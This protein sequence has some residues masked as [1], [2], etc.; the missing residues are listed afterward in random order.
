MASNCQSS[1]LHGPTD[2]KSHYFGCLKVSERER[3]LKHLPE[4]SRAQVEEEENRIY[5]LRLILE[6]DSAKQT[7]EGVFLSRHKQSLRQ[8]RN[9]S[10]VV[11]KDGG[12]KP[13]P[14]PSIT[15]PTSTVLETFTENVDIYANM[16][17]F[18]DSIPHTLPEFLPAEFPDQKIP[19]TQLLYDEDPLRNPLTRKCA[20]GMIQYFHVPANDMKWVEVSLLD[21]RC[22][23]RISERI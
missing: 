1:F 18:K 14:T 21:F 12:K 11:E 23:V 17:F 8:W 15:S 4:R 6:A 10:N 16:L 9:P 3:F 2:I 5:H 13:P 20:D 22:G 19:L 7:R